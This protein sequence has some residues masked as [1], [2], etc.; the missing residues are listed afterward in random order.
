MKVQ[1]SRAECL[2][3]YVGVQYML[4]Q[5]V[6]IECSISFLNLQ[7]ISGFL[8]LSRKHCIPTVLFNILL[9]VREERYV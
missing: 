7:S 8:D 1:Y 5:V 6:F 9:I 4:C 3:I 2:A